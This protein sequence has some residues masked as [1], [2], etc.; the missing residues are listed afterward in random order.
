MRGSQHLGRRWKPL[1]ILVIGGPALRGSVMP[2]KLIGAVEV[3]DA[4][5]CRL[6]N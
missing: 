6:T 5:K 1:D 3:L 2:V 4:T